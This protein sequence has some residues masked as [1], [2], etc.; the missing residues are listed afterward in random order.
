MEWNPG[1]WRVIAQALRARDARDEQGL[2]FED[3]PALLGVGWSVEL[4]RHFGRQPGPRLRLR[5]WDV[6]GVGNAS[7]EGYSEPRSAPEPGRESRYWV[8]GTRLQFERP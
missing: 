8:F 7:V 5:E 1:R 3:L 4:T 6:P 2:D